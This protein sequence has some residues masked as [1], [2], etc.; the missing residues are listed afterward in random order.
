MPIQQDNNKFFLIRRLI[1]VALFLSLFCMFLLPGAYALE[2]RSDPDKKDNLFIIKDIIVTGSKITS[3]EAILRRV[4]YRQGK[5]F[6]PR[7]SAEAINNIFSMDNFTQVELEGEKLSDTEMNLYINL[8]EKKAV[9]SLVIQGNQKLSLSKI[10]QKVPLDKVVMIDEKSAHALAQQIKHCYSEEQYYHTKVTPVLKNADDNSEKV[11]LSFV[12]EEGTKGR[13]VHVEFRGNKNLSDRLLRSHIHSREDWLLA[14]SDGSGRYHPDAVEMDKRIIERMYY[15]HGYLMA[16][17]VKTDVIFSSD[18]AQITLIFRIQEGEQFRLDKVNVVTEEVLSEQEILDRIGIQSGDVYV[19]DK[20]ALAIEVIKNLWGEKGYIFADVYPQVKPDE[21]TRTVSLT[22]QV[23][24]GEK[25]FARRITIMG[26]RAT[27]D[28]V[29]RRQLDIVEGDLITMQ[30]LES[31]RQMVE[32]LSFFER[33]GVDWKIHKIDNDLAD[34]DLIVNETKT[35]DF[36]FAL[37][38][39]SQNEANPHKITSSLSLSKRNFRGLGYDIGGIIQANASRHTLLNFKQAEFHFINPHLFDSD[40]EGAFF[41]YYK[42]EEHDQ[43]YGFKRNPIQ[44]ILGTNARIGFRLPQLGRNTQVVVDLGV[45]QLWSNRLDIKDELTNSKIFSENQAFQAFFNKTFQEGLIEWIGLQIEKDVRNHRIYPSEGYRIAA[46]VKCAPSLINGT[47]SFLKTDIEASYYASLIGRDTLVLALHGKIGNI[48]TI[49]ATRTI[50]Y[51]ELFQMG[52]QNTVRGFI[53]GSIGPAWDFGQGRTAPLGSRHS[54]QFNSE[55]IFPLI[56]DYSMKAHLFYD[57]GAGWSPPRDAIIGSI[58]II[59]ENFD[60]R[61]SVGFGLNILRPTAVKID[62]GYK[63]DRK[64]KYDE[65]PH[66]FHLN[67]NYAW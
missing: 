45:E 51:R 60:L 5:L 36:N 49:S 15:N 34:L 47:F 43:F 44:N 37:S 38:Y 27:R 64:K 20:V 35:G 48:Q 62:W 30:A 66:E 50:P 13:L 11:A 3:I 61:H 39:G 23:S 10:K 18:N 32:Y 14:F 6:D 58:P 8:I 9:A 2:M 55:L 19:Y 41:A 1:S 56:P 26:N 21:A 57:A 17:V 67:M 33:G 52:G 24:K 31:S 53:R 7:L 22:F 28:K 46:S 40:V 25:L 4:P 16:K 12:I 29:I 63:L 54:V 42:T 65:S 59:R